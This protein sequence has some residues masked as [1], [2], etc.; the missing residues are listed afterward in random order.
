MVCNCA[1]Y[2]AIFG[3]QQIADYLFA[4]C[5]TWAVML[6]LYCIF[7]PQIF[8][9]FTSNTQNNTKSQIR[10]SFL[11]GRECLTVDGKIQRDLCKFLLLYDVLK[12]SF[13]FNVILIIAGFATREDL[14]EVWTY[15]WD[16]LPI[17]SSVSFAIF[18]SRKVPMAMT[19]DYYILSIAQPFLRTQIDTTTS[20]RWRRGRFYHRRTLRKRCDDV[21]DVDDEDRLK[22]KTDIF[23]KGIIFF[24]I[25]I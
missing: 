4:A 24:N 21:D 7:A 6:L 17:L 1:W 22:W 5:H 9:T 14:F 23:A 20:R 16:F 11:A 15:F 2:L 13:F 10:H 12:Y 18:S 25:S 8:R 19:I 3:A